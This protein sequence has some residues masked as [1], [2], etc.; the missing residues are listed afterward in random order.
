MFPGVDIAPMAQ[1]GG[2][3]TA[4]EG[5][6]LLQDRLPRVQRNQRSKLRPQ[7]CLLF[8]MLQEWLQDQ[9]LLF[10]TFAGVF[11]APQFPSL[12]GSMGN[13]S[14]PQSGPA[15]PGGESGMTGLAGAAGV[16]GAADQD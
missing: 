14:F 11:V 2:G 1:D 16:A 13:A 10:L 12:P 4:Q 7:D 15:T 3:V 6:L 5:Q 9:W 8:L